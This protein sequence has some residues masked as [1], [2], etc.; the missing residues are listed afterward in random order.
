MGCQRG[1]VWVSISDLTVEVTFSQRGRTQ[2]CGPGCDDP[3]AGVEVSS[4]LSGIMLWTLRVRGYCPNSRI[5][6]RERG[7][8]ILYAMQV[9]AAAV[10]ELQNIQAMISKYTCFE[11]SAANVLRRPV[12]RHRAADEVWLVM[13][14]NLLKTRRRS[15]SFAMDRV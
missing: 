13:I 4:G 2:S 15:Q 12:Y 7:R 10:Q 6:L 9:M 3:V 5:T 14:T 1:V 11:G 8:H